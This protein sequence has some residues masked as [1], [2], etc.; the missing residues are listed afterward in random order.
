MR[1]PPVVE[2]RRYALHPG[3]RETLIELFDST[4]VEP[5]EEAGMTVIGQFRDLDDPNAFVWLRGFDDMDG[6]TAGLAAFYEGPVWA[7][8][9]EAANATMVDSDDVL[10]LRPARPDTGFRLDGRARPRHG[11]DRARH[12]VT[13]TVLPLERAEDEAAAVA[14]FESAMA[15]ELSAAGGRLL[16]TFVTE[17]AANGYPRL[18]VRE[19]EHVLVWFTGVDDPAADDAAAAAFVPVP[20]A[21]PRVVLRL[22]P[23][24]R[25]LLDGDSGE[26][27]R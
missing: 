23:T 24:A 11:D 17:P 18:P 13:A 3:C 1:S 22:E 15:P 7:R 12:L 5:Q 2:L 25:S 8:H 9:R 26:T 27:T 21:G 19:G 10:L 16:G 20:L 4:F 14:W 6:R